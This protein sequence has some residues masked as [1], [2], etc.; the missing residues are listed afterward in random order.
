MIVD[1]LTLA[2]IA[3]MCGD[4]LHGANLLQTVRRVSKD[5]RTL[6][7]GDLYLALRGENH[8]GNA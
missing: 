1:A 6:V 2:E 3:D 8:D 4:V 5:T 7:P